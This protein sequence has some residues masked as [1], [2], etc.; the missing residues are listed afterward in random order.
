MLLWELVKK[1]FLVFVSDRKA[2]IITFLVPICIATFL[3]S[4]MGNISG[5]GS[6]S[7]KIPILVVDEDK[8]PVTAQILTAITGSKSFTTQVVSL[9]NAKQQIHDGRVGTAVIFGKGFGPAAAA[10]LMA[11]SNASRPTLQV[12]TDPSKSME[13][14]AAEGQLIQTI[15]PA[16]VKQSVGQAPDLPFKVENVPQTSGQKPIPWSGSAHAF[17][18]LGVQAL[19]FG[20]ME[21]AM[22]IMRDRRMGIWSRL[23]ASPASK[24]TILFGKFVG[25]TLLA[26]LI[27]MGV[28]AV[29]ALVY[30]YRILGSWPGFLLVCIGIA[31]MTAAAGLFIAALGRTE[32][33][34]RGL[35][36]LV[37]LSMLM[38]GGAWVPIFV[39]PQWVQSISLLTPVR[40]AVDGIDLMTWRGGSFSDA[41]RCAGMLALFAAILALVAGRRFRWAADEV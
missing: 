19:F 6:E 30:G 39:F 18:G 3:G 29:G 10:S 35:S 20:A 11:G 36:I 26:F 24:W 4:I 2:M 28:F 33:Q 1:D 38:L 23:R 14:Q 34:S 13:T 7:I 16:I 31:A 5:G 41:A 40:W 15:V 27:F 32:Q 8:S 22:G 37:I 25:S 21:A 17:A 12:L 9:E